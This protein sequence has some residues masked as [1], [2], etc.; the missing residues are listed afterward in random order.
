MTRNMPGK[1]YIYLILFI[2]LLHTA[3]RQ[4]C[5]YEDYRDINKE[6]WCR[7]EVVEFETTIPDSGRYMVSVFLR[8]TTDYEMA[9]L[10]CFLSTRSSAAQE[11]KDTLNI[12]VAEPDG[13][14]LGDG[15][16]VKTIRQPLHKNPVVLPKGTVTFRIE[17][18]MRIECLKGVKN[19]G[20]E[21][22]KAI[23]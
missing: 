6:D 9:N 22:V 4:N 15:N 21:I 14:W 20:L 7:S 1:K 17:Q 10:W 16:M 5:V 18:G 13:R 23:N 19:I 12:K 3:C 8:H 2:L 11:L